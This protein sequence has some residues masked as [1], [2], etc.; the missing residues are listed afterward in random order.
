MVVSDEDEQLEPKTC[1]LPPHVVHL[2]G[3]L[4]A[5]GHLSSE[6]IDGIEAALKVDMALPLD[7]R[8]RQWQTAL[9]QLN[10]LGRGFR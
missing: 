9:K 6:K 10:E 4:R 2:I 7:E 5:S 1:H 8:C 3:R